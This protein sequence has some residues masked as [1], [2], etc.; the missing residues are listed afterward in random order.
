MRSPCP[1]GCCTEW[2]ASKITGAP[3]LRQHRQRAHVGDQRVVAERHAALGDQHIAIAGA[4][5]FGTTLAMSHGARNWPF[6]TLT[7]R[8]VLA[9]AT[10]R[11]VCRQRNAGICKISTT[12]ATRAH[13]SGSCTS[14][15]TGTPSFSRSS[16][17]IASALSRPM[18]RA[19]LRAGAVRL[20]E[21]GFVDEADAEPRGD[22]LQRR[23][24]FERM[25]AAFQRARAGDQG[26][27]AVYCRSA[28]CRR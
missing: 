4:G 6:L 25:R 24:H 7:A 21:R 11:S 2:V 17:K 13:C 22:L 16:A 12:S 19:L 23:R 9:A 3:V 8:P 18:P 1:P 14:V 10:N 28:P 26:R 20:V 5:D 27:A 15:S